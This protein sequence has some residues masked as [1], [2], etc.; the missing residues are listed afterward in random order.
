MRNCLKNH[1]SFEIAKLSTFLL[2]LEL[3][4]GPSDRNGNAQHIVV[5][6][7][8]QESANEVFVVAPRRGGCWGE[9]NESV[10]TGFAT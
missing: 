2:D 9:K 1:F 8:P 10:N 5:L 7:L 3:T 4:P 6:I